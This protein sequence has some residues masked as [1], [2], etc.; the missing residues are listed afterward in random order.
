MTTDEFLVLF[1]IIQNFSIA[2]LRKGF[3]I[4][5]FFDS[6]P[7]QLNGT[8][9]KKIKDWFI[10]YIKK[11]HQEGKIEEQVMF[12]LLSESNLKRLTKISDLNSEHLME[13][14]IIFEITEVSFAKNI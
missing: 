12:P 14:F 2:N 5:K 6:Y 7:S 1:Q 4:P 8:R 9:K 11:L 10:H 3:D 13:P